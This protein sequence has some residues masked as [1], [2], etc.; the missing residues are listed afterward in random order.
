MNVLLYF[1]QKHFLVGTG[2]STLNDAFQRSIQKI[3]SDDLA[4]KFSLKG[5][6]GKK[7]LQDFSN[8]IMALK[9]F[10]I[11]ISLTRI[12]YDLY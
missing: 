8:L 5:K 7:S 10:L 11:L 3:M 2:G 12:C 6:R 9:G 4:V 1:L